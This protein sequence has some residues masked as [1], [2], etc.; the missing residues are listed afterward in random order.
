MDYILSPT[1]TVFL[2]S[3]SFEAGL[4]LLAMVI[5]SASSLKDVCFHLMEVT[6]NCHS[7]WEN[8][9]TWHLCS[10]CRC[11]AQ[12]SCFCGWMLRILASSID[13]SFHMTELQNIVTSRSERE[14]LSGRSLS[15][16]QDQHISHQTEV[17]I[18]GSLSALIRSLV[19]FFCY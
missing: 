1:F 14:R 5:V 19:L 3:S 12:S 2:V 15:R 18:T 13:W 17:R 6:C 9:L 11:R 10:Y 7:P 4:L 16:G 8:G